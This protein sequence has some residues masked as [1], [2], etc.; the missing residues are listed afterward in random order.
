MLM[1]GLLVLG[2]LA[3]LEPLVEVVRQV[4]LALEAEPELVRS[5]ELEVRQPASAPTPPLPSSPLAWLLASAVL[6][7]GSSQQ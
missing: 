7:S 1:L 6:F 3:G 2:P 4:K 5:L